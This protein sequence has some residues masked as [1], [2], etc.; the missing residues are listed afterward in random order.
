MPIGIRRARFGVRRERQRQEGKL[1]VLFE[2]DN[3]PGEVAAL[4]IDLET[5]VDAKMRPP[6]FTV[7]E[8]EARVGGVQALLLVVPAVEVFLHTRRCGAS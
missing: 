6:N 3:G 7:V 1:V 8:V 4:A 5:D 2:N